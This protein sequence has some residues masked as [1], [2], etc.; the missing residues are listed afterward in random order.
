MS[1]SHAIRTLKALIIIKGMDL[2]GSGQITLLTEG[3]EPANA[4]VDLES[5]LI[6]HFLAQLPR[7]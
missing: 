2:I 6:V 4:G 1:N 3:F 5:V 7:T